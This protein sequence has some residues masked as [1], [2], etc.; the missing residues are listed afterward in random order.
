VTI[1]FDSNSTFA[2]YKKKTQHL[3]PHNENIVHILEF[4]LFFIIVSFIGDAGVELESNKIATRK[5][6]SNSAH[7]I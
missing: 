4:E 7:I 6:G 2:A 5:I 1:L 3:R